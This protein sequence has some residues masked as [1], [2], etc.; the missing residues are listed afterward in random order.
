MGSIGPFVITKRNQRVQIFFIARHYLTVNE[1]NS[2]ILPHAMPSRRILNKAVNL[3]VWL[4]VLFM[5]GT[6]VGLLLLG[7]QYDDGNVS[8][9]LAAMDPSKDFDTPN[10][11]KPVRAPNVG[12]T[13]SLFLVET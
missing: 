8:G 2:L 7:T 1:S 6:I 13:T 12:P 11:I 4:S 10:A 5:G 3:L 9:R